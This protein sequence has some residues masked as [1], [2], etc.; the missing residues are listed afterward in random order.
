[1]KGHYFS[2]STRKNPRPERK[3]QYSRWTAKENFFI[4]KPVTFALIP[5][6]RCLPFSTFLCPMSTTSKQEMILQVE[7]YD[8]IFPSTKPM[9]FEPMPKVSDPPLATFLHP[10]YSSR[11]HN[12]SEYRICLRDILY[13]YIKSIETKPLHIS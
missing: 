12:G 9:T 11:Q 3:M 2:L 5:E 6:V 8:K 1:M 4:K 13:Y 7:T 10:M